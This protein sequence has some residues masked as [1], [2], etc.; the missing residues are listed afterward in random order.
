MPVVP[1][2]PV[3]HSSNDKPCADGDRDALVERLLGLSERALRGPA[4]RRSG[5]GGSALVGSLG[6]VRRSGKRARPDRPWRASGQRPFP[7]PRSV[8]T[9][10]AIVAR[11]MRSS[12][13]GSAGGSFSRTL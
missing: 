13:V 10:L 3:A 8:P 5:T 4:E 6:G 12:S 11:P 9:G 7:R 1:F 2:A